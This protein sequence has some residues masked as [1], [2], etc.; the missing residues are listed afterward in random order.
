MKAKQWM[1]VKF[2]FIYLAIHF[3]IHTFFFSIKEIG[4]LKFFKFQRNM[5]LHKNKA[6]LPTGFTE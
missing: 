3:L 2:F 6:L 1:F 5:Q 4:N